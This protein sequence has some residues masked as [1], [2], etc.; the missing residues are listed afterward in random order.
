MVGTMK[1]SEAI[2]R[3]NLLDGREIVIEG[4]LLA[5]F[6]EAYVSPSKENRAK[7]SSILIDLESFSDILSAK[8]VSP[9]IGTI[10]VFT[11][12]VKIRGYLSVKNTDE[13]G[14]TLTQPKTLQLSRSGRSSNVTF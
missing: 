5:T 11:G 8:G 3:K 10:F 6:E 13:Y 7:S 12:K 4:F 14:A 1:V 9:N 2:D